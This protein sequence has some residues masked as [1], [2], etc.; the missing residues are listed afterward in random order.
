MND[1]YTEEELLKMAERSYE[2]TKQNRHHDTTELPMLKKIFK[3]GKLNFDLFKIGFVE[4]NDDEDF[5]L[6]WAL[7]IDEKEPGF[8][9]RIIK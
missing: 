5:I 9:K 6:S 2:W 7:Y 3:R 8:I 1:I 4:Y